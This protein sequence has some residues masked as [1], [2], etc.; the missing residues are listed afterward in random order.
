MYVCIYIYTYI[1]IYPIIRMNQSRNQLTAQESQSPQTK[2][3]EQ[4]R[5]SGPASGC[6]VPQHLSRLAVGHPPSFPSRPGSLVATHG[7][8]PWKKRW[9]HGCLKQVKTT[10]NY[11]AMASIWLPYHI[12]ILVYCKVQQL[13]KQHGIG[14]SKLGGQDGG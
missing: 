11:G 1:H 8:K 4:P 9:R 5:R 6:S 14:P 13:G 3:T 10:K 7:V 12:S 2:N